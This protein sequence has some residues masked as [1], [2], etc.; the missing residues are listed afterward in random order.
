MPR[1]GSAS[2][3]RPA[4]LADVVV[5]ADSA[6]L[7]RDGIEARIVLGDASAWPMG[8]TGQAASTYAA[9]AR[10]AA[11]CPLPLR[12]ADAFDGL[13]LCL[14]E[15]Q[16]T[17]AG[18]CVW[19]GMQ[20]RNAHGAAALSRPGAATPTRCARRARP[21]A[22]FVDGRISAAGIAAAGRI[23]GGEADASADSPLAS[24][25]KAQLAVAQLVGAGLTS[26]EIAEQLYLSP[27]TVDNHLAQIYRQ[28][29]HPV[30]GQARPRRADGGCR[31]KTPG[32]QDFAIAAAH[33]RGAYRGQRDGVGQVRLE[34]AE[35]AEQPDPRHGRGPDRPTR[36]SGVTDDRA[37]PSP[38]TAP[39]TAHCAPAAMSS[40][41][42][43][44]SSPAIPRRQR[45]F[46]GRE[47]DLALR[48]GTYPK[49]VTA[50]MRGVV[51][52][53]GLGL[54]AHVTHRPIAPDARIAMPETA[55]G[56]FPDV[57]ITRIFARAP[58]ELGTYAAVTGATFGAADAVL[59]GLADPSGDFGPAP[60]LVQQ[61]WIDECFAG[62]D[63]RT[64]I[65]RPGLVPDDARLRCA[66]V[67][68]RRW[69]TADRPARRVGRALARGADAASQADLAETLAVDTRLARGMMLASDFT[70]GVRAKLVDKDDRPR[71]R[72][73]RIEDVTPRRRRRP[74]LLRLAAPAVS[75]PWRPTRI[76]RAMMRDGDFVEGVRARLVDKD[77]ARWRHTNQKAVTPAE[78]TAFLA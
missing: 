37:R 73:A 71:W 55:I 33:G 14:R 22:W 9:A 70:E 76:A 72:Q 48:L 23:E 42:A 52:G 66:R 47:Y 61:N 69:T 26:K 18:R 36:P 60:I 41:S 16:P 1:A 68:R 58:G 62:D 19:L 13:A 64:Q 57:G 45:T 21:M 56:F 46:L 67:R 4:S 77:E 49:P 44:P 38:S 8:D 35:G 24:L 40:P 53:G 6:R 20:L 7:E 63:A 29:R 25:T 27:R 78:V 65:S 31:M 28:P 59:L 43:P 10:H 34:P 17:H 51:M 50:H 11:A 39:E 74:G 3:A 15:T 32:P 30:A 2:S 5:L 12:V 54:S 75:R